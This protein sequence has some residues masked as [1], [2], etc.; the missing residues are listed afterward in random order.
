MHDVWPKNVH[1]RAWNHIFPQLNKI[2]YLFFNIFLL[3]VDS[4]ILVKYLSL[5]NDLFLT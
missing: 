2:I 3:I 5:E 4:L 1:I